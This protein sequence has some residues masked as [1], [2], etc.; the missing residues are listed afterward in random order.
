VCFPLL[1]LQLW[2]LSDPFALFDIIQYTL[3]NL[4]SMWSI[5][6]YRGVKDIKNSSMSRFLFR[7]LPPQVE[8]GEVITYILGTVLHAFC[9]KFAQLL[10]FA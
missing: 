9:S 3:C 1:L 10:W 2:E 4:I 6:L 7:G 5:I 8:S